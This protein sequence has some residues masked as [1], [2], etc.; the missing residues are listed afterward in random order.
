[1][2]AIRL[3]MYKMP[4]KSF[5][6]KMCFVQDKYGRNEKLCD[7]VVLSQYVRPE[8]TGTNTKAVTDQIFALS[9]NHGSC[10]VLFTCAATVDQI[11]SN[12]SHTVL[13]KQSYCMAK[14]LSNSFDLYS[15]LF[16]H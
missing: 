5:L 8:L 12:H 6:Q 2:E 3:F 4:M 11:W 1:M 15:C 9:K 14:L 13:M 16:S 10:G 7:F